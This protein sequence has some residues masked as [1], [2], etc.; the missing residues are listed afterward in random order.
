MGI[1]WLPAIWLGGFLF[2]AS[3]LL[4]GYLTPGYSHFHQ[5]ISELGERNTAH[6]WLV[7]W[8]GF[9]PLGLSFVIF[10]HQTRELFLS[11]IPAAL[12]LLTGLAVIVAG[13]FPTD[14]DNRRDTLS[15]KVHAKAVIALLFLLSATPFAFSI[16]ALYRDPPEVWFMVFSFLMGVVVL[17]F[18]GMLPNDACPWL[19]ALHRKIFGRFLEIWYPLQGLHQRLH[20]SLFGIWWIVFTL[21]L[22]NP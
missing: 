22:A 8:L 19:V 3:I 17:G 16:S 11:F 10:A 2:G 4:A 18:Y 5:S 15:G 14:P 13:I 7:R 20:L 12:L 21:V 1:D 9:V 6:A